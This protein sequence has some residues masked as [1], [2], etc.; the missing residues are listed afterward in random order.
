MAK[1]I[2]RPNAPIWTRPT[3]VARGPRLDRD[4]IAG[5]ALAIADA[6]GFA[7]VSMRR[8]ALA[9]DVGTMTLYYYVKTKDDL[10]ALMHDA[11]MAE[12]VVPADQLPRG[13]RA[14]LTA[15]ARTSRGVFARHPWA[16]YFLQGVRIGPNGMRHIEQ[17]LAAVAEVPLDVKGKVRMLSL[18]DEYVA[19]HVLQANEAALHAMEH[20]VLRPI[21]EFF[22]AKLGTGAFPHLEAMIGG[23]DALTVF[24]RFAGWVTEDAWFESGLTALLDGMEPWIHAPGDADPAPPPASR[25][26][27][28][29]NRAASAPRPR[30]PRATAAER[31]PAPPIEP[32][33]RRAQR[34]RARV[35]RRRR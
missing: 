35:D 18:V 1:Q 22:A 31:P 12:V 5:A 25:A 24:S 21:A 3:R 8:V 11:I 32:E 33:V 2:A 7:A 14:G 34:R 6:E 15:I 17:S 10:V 4:Q 29:G 30:T 13:W 27:S 23:E 28:P 16:L 26:R 20:K 9:L 19:G